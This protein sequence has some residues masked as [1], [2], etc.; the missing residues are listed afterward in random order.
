MNSEYVFCFCV[1]FNLGSSVFRSSMVCFRFFNDSSYMNFWDKILLHIFVFL[2]DLNYQRLCSCFPYLNIR[3]IYTFFENSQN[4]FWRFFF[5]YIFWKYVY[6][7]I[8]HA[9]YIGSGFQE[10]F[11]MNQLLFCSNYLQFIIRKIF[12][13]FGLLW[14][15]N[16]KQKYMTLTSFTSKI[17]FEYEIQ[18]TI[19]H[20]SM[21]KGYRY[22]KSLQLSYNYNACG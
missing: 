11:F 5:M 15:K 7:A 6:S 10:S 14:N 13:L 8:P 20:F 4:T 18:S 9:H 16:I 3:Y 21:K 22:C 1:C 19:E 17:R 2:F 12:I